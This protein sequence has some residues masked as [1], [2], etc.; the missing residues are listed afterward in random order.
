MGAALVSE[1]GNM[2]QLLKQDTVMLGLPSPVVPTTALQESA[3]AARGKRSCRK[4]K[5]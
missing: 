2:Q 1:P 5:M 3:G 4:T